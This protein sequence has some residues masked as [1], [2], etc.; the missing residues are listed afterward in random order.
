ME[1]ELYGDSIPYGYTVHEAFEQGDGLEGIWF[2]KYWPSA[3]ETMQDTSEMPTPDFTNFDSASTKL[4]YWPEGTTS[5]TTKDNCI[6]IE[7]NPQDS[8][9]KEI[10]KDGKK[11]YLYDYSSRIWPNIVTEANGEQMWWVWIPR[12]AYKI[13]N[14][15]TS[16]VLLDSNNKPL[17]SKFG[18]TIPTQYGYKLHEAFEQGD[19]LKGIWF[20]KYWPSND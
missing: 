5:S 18:N 9:Q 13:E 11:Y 2:S 20:S 14:G 17:D 10:E 4:V 3:Q 1:Q 12:Y 19:G 16:I 6:F 8:I 7:Y 15:I